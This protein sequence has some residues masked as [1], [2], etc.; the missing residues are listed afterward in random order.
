MSTTHTSS[1]DLPAA[2]PTLDPDG[3]KTAGER[4]L[5]WFE[6]VVWHDHRVC[7]NC[8]ARVRRSMEGTVTTPEGKRREVDES[9]RTTTAM[10]GE[11]L[12]PAPESAVGIKPL[13][14]PRTTCLECGSVGCRVAYDTL[15][16]QEAIDRVPELVARI[17][18]QGHRIDSGVVFDAVR[19]LKTHP[20]YQG[21]DKHVF[22]AAAALGA[23]R[24]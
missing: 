22:A 16:V 3:D 5:E 24:A 21:D 4:A 19:H 14:R 20:T 17:G 1:E 12:E 15:S 11:D 9:W 13:A 6:D 18:E 10:L 23:D 2:T 8:F 7:A